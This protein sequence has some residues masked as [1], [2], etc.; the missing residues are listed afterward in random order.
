VI[1]FGEVIAGLLKW[2]MFMTP[3]FR[4]RERQHVGKANVEE[5]LIR[6]N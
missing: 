2:I 1:S 5:V 6:Q 4:G 3:H